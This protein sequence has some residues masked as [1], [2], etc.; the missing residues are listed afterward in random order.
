MATVGA[1]V[2]KEDGKSV[3]NMHIPFYN[4]EQFYIGA[5]DKKENDNAPA[6]VVYGLYGRVGGIWDKVDKSGKSYRSMN[7]E[8]LGV[9][10]NFAIFACEN[11]EVKGGVKTHNI[12]YSVPKS[13]NDFDSHSGEPQKRRD[14][15]SIPVEIEIDDEIPF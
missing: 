2:K 9:K 3:I 1:V 12:V 10:I 14:T 11:E 6:F 4:K 13:S 7:I 8:S 15:Q 5:N